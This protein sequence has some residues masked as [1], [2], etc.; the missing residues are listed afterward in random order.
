MMSASHASTGA[1]E[2][3]PARLPF[4]RG[5]KGSWKVSGA[6]DSLCYVRVRLVSI[7]RLLV[8]GILMCLASISC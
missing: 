6:L 3:P 8:E 7:Y 2:R 1:Y 5:M 4:A